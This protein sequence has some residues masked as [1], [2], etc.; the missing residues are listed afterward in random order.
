M[1]D[2]AVTNKDTGLG[3]SSGIGPQAGKLSAI[4][5]ASAATVKGEAELECSG[6]FSARNSVFHRPL[7][8]SSTAEDANPS[9]GAPIDAWKPRRA[10]LV[11]PPNWPSGVPR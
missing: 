9:A 2:P 4:N 1:K 11:S 10:S 8:R 3:Y 6:L 5:R 7:S